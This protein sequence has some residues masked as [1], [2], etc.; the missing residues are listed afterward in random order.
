MAYETNEGTY[1]FISRLTALPFFLYQDI[2]DVFRGLQTEAN[3]EP[4]RDLVQYIPVNWI[5]GT[6]APKDWSIYGEAMR[7]NNDV[8]GWHNAPL[9]SEQTP[10]PGKAAVSKTPTVNV[11]PSVPEA[12]KTRTCSV[13]LPSRFADFDMKR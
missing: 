11:E 2:P 3:T 4:V 13:K 12:Q 8:E 1:L 9:M 10:S 6:A 7:T 5:N